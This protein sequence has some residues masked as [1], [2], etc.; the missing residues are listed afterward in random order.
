MSTKEHPP[1]GTPC[2]RD[3]VVRALLGIDIRCCLFSAI[4]ASVVV[5]AGVSILM[6]AARHNGSQD[7]LEALH[8]NA[9]VMALVFNESQIPPTERKELLV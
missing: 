8:V 9:N 6:T 5:F 2:G 3:S 1:K 7:D 4:L